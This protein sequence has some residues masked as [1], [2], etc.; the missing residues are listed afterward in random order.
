MPT[1]EARA[2]R[3]DAIPPLFLGASA[4]ARRVRDE[5]ARA[6]RTEAT[7]LIQGESGV[8]KEL[9]AREIHLRSRRSRGPFVALNCAAIPDTLLESEIFGHEAGAY[10][11]ARLAH[12][13]ALE[14]AHGGTL[15]LD[16]VGDLSPQAQP[17][18]LRALEAGESVRVGGERARPL[19][20]RFVSATNHP[21]RAMAKDGRFRLDLYYRLRVIEVRV[22][23]LR[24]R[25]DDIVSLAEH[26]ARLAMTAS[27]RGFD[28]LTPES[29]PMLLAHRWP[30]NVRELR[31]VIER[32]IAL[33]PSPRLTVDDSCLDLE[34]DPRITLRGLF[35]K[36]WKLARSRFE[37]AYAA[38]L[39]EKHGGDVRK[40]A[41]AAGL[42]PRSLYKMLRRLG[43]RPGPEPPEGGSGEEG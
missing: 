35:S 34:T 42:V 31:S 20:V 18:L 15:F 2:S 13:G 10:T 41:Q 9:V 30:G 5:I 38:H 3:D 14:Q 23:P 25:L 33:D 19:D 21:L 22:P 27:G 1:T 16:E 12:R 28:G 8:G 37:A 11:D 4:A 24:D 40:A 32:A 36:E 39:I 6:A 43:L 17:K 29:I 7:I 26:F